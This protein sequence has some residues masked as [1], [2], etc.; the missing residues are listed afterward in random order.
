MLPNNI[1]ECA[2]GGYKLSD[3]ITDI[4]KSDDIVEV[5]IGCEEDDSHLKIDDNIGRV[6]INLEL[7]DGSFSY[8]DLEDVLIFARQYCNGIYERVWNDVMP[9]G[10]S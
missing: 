7:K 6:K 8:I 1:Q 9:E 2:Y 5:Y 3:I 4:D 10:K